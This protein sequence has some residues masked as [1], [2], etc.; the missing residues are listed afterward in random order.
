M[1]RQVISEGTKMLLSSGISDFKSFLTV[2]DVERISGLK[3][4]RQIPFHPM[5]F[6]GSELN[7]VSESGNKILCV[8]FFEAK[9]FGTYKKMTSRNVLA[10]ISGVGDEACAG[11]DPFDKSSML[12][13][14]KGDHAVYMNT[15]A[16]NKAYQ[17]ALNL[18]QLIKIGKVVA[19]RLL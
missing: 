18:D 11:Q 15:T 19:S 14:R 2:E 9:Q 16:D 7:F 17:N 5:K 6:L 10:S 12:I 8:D 13:F 4:V 3:K 1:D